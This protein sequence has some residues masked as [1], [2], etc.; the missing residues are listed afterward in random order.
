MG[1]WDEGARGHDALETLLAQNA[2]RD[3]ELVPLRHQRMAISPWNYYRARR[4]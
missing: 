4:R 2:M 3:P 1:E